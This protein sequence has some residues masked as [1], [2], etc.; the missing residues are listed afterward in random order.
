V[1]ITF[2]YPA[3]KPALYAGKANSAGV[4]TLSVTIPSNRV[5]KT[6]N[7]LLVLLLAQ[8]GKLKANAAAQFTLLR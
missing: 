3:G 8:S 6:N 5:T 1:N 7:T 2:K 4:Y